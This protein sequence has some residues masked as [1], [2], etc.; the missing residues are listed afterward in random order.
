MGRHWFAQEY[1]CEFVD[2]GGGW[3]TRDV[4]EAAFSGD[5]PLFL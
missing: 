1:M 5:E 2:N 3:F 4:V